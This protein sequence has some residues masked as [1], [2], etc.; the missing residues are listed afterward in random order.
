MND[1]SAAPLDCAPATP[2][3]P[4]WILAILSFFPVTRHIPVVSSSSPFRL[5]SH[6]FFIIA[7]SCAKFFPI[8]NIRFPPSFSSSQCSHTASFSFASSGFQFSKKRQIA[9]AILLS[10][11]FKIAR[12]LSL[13]ALKYFIASSLFSFKLIPKKRPALSHKKYDETPDVRVTCSGTH[14]VEGAQ[15]LLFPLCIS[16][17]N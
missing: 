11:L 5:S 1:T 14:I 16:F 6:A 4:L 2:F 17:F 13:A 3:I 12:C 10:T 9:L 7:S 15:M 8:Q